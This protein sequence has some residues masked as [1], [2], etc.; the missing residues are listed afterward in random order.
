VA[1]TVSIT[2]RDRTRILTSGAIVVQTRFVVNFRHPTTG[3]RKQIF[4]KSHKE[5]IARRD[6]LIAGAVTGSLTVERTNLSVAEA[7]EH[8]LEN[9]KPDVKKATWQGYRNGAH[10]IIG[11]LLIGT[12][13]E[14]RVFTWKG[15][16]SSPPEFVTM[17]G[18]IRVGD[19]STGQI[20]SWHR[21]VSEHIG[22]YSA[23]LAKKFLRAA[24]A[25]ATEDF[26]LRVPAM[27]SKLGRGRPKTKK[28]ILTPEQVGLLLKAAAGDKRKGIYYAFPFLT[29]V[30]PSEQLGLLWED[31][32]LE[33][34][35]IRIRR[36]LER[37]GSISEFTKTAAGTREIP[38][39]PLLKSLLLEWRLACPRRSGE[40]YLVFPG[41]G[42]KGGNGRRNGGR[43]LVYANF[44]NRYWKPALEAMGLPHV[45]PHSARHA[46]ISTL[47]A[48]GVEVGLVAK[49]AGHANAAITL[50]HYTQAVR[51]GADAVEAL[52]QAYTR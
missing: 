27:P 1:F 39:S 18:H 38:I 48:Q 31:V 30:R 36:M 34:G 2:K 9:R 41:H 50:S 13:D 10:N 14:R 4:V 40:L 23:N 47:Q 45:T 28:T 17:L 51:G 25:L 32:N 21:T 11:P 3:Q 8:W 33:A 37:D 52:E 42:W 7:V 20:R 44:R 19:L 12:S 46:F 22:A 35:V 24:L 49:L 43:T 5:A 16:K 6:E 29:G 15:T 26:G